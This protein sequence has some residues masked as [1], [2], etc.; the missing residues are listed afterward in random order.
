MKTHFDVP[1]PIL[2]CTYTNVAVDH[3][4]E[5]LAV[6]T[7]NP[8][9]IGYNGKVKSSLVSHTLEA[10]LEVHPLAPERRR[11]KGLVEAYRQREKDLKERIW[12]LRKKQV[13]M[14]R[15][16]AM[17]TELVSL[18]RQIGA[19]RAKEYALYLR[20]V[21]DILISADVVGVPYCCE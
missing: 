16:L 11:L 5:G 8:V 4:L 12:D 2:L 7:L 20:M 21:R 6:A 10:K 15:L 3:L 17:E 1:Y 14:Y 13:H 18:E 9:R 19:L